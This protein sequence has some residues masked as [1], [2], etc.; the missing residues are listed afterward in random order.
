MALTSSHG[1]SLCN[2]SVPSANCIHISSEFF[3]SN[4]PRKEFTSSRSPSRLYAGITSCW[5][6]YGLVPLGQVPLLIQLFV[7]RGMAPI[8][9]V[10]PFSRN[11]V[12]VSA[13][14]DMSSVLCP[15]YNTLCQKCKDSNSR[16]FLK[17]YI[18][19]IRE[20]KF[21]LPQHLIS[22]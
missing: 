21:S 13:A 16:W 17:F 3:N 20:E 9:G 2:F 14:G 5:S 7:T 22:S 18:V 19:P 8:T 11:W 1:F 10:G 6:Y 12:E 4:I 15:Q